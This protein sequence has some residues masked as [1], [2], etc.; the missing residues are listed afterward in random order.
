MASL[1]YRM[2]MIDGAPA[3]L[4]GLVE[5]FD[6]LFEKEYQPNETNIGEVLIQG[7]RQNN[8]I[9]KPAISKYKE[10]LIH[11]YRNY[12]QN[13]S[14]D[15]SVL[16]KDYST[17]EGHPRENIPWFPTISAELCDGC[18]KC[19][20]ICPKGV[21]VINGKGKAI[22]VEPFLCIV[23]CC[24]CKSACDPGA[25]LMPNRNILD[26]FRHGQRRST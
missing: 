14:G 23:G 15:N 21:F 10:V 13:R 22:V 4:L 25:I 9:P 17:W 18:G 20:E 5:L 24:F 16:A 2:L 3:G 1:S 7:I 6:T 8:F 19:L 11:E 12:Y 26:Q